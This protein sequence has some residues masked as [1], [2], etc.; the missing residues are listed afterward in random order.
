MVSRLVTNPVARVHLSTCGDVM[1][2]MF[3]EI[4]HV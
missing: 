1:D 4:G 3:G 2:M